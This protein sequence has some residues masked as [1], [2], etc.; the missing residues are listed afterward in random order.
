MQVTPVQ[1]IKGRA[2]FLHGVAQERKLIAHVSCVPNSIQIG[3]GLKRTVFEVI[4]QA[5][6]LQDAGRIGPHL[7]ARAKPFKGRG[8][9]KDV[10]HNAQL[11]QRMGTG[12]AANA[13]TND[14]DG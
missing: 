5:K 2:V 12:Q 13:C 1:G 4:G 6:T 8:L 14:G 11:A 7:N 3:S 9:F 10:G